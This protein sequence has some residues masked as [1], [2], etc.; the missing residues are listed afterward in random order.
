MK[1]VLF[2]LGLRRKNNANRSEFAKG[3]ISGGELAYD[4]GENATTIAGSIKGAVIGTSIGA[5]VG[6]VAGTVAGPAGTAVGVAVGSVA[7]AIA[8]TVVG[9]VVASEVYATAVEFGVENADKIADGSRLF[10]KEKPAARP[11]NNCNNGFIH[12]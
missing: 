10:A 5:K 3:E 12:N 8:G 9:C 6:A 1:Y 7:G 4:L 11:E 2:C